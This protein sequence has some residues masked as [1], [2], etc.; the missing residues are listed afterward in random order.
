VDRAIFE[1]KQVKARS[2][3]SLRQIRYVFCSGSSELRMP[4]S[5]VGKPRIIYGL[6]GA[7]VKICAAAPTKSP[8]SHHPLPLL[9]AKTDEQGIAAAALHKSIIS[10]FHRMCAFVDS[11]MVR[12]CGV[13]GHQIAPGCTSCTIF[14]FYR[15]MSFLSNKTIKQI[16]NNRSAWTL[17]QLPIYPSL[18]DVLMKSEDSDAAASAVCSMLNSMNEAQLSSML[19]FGHHTRPLSFSATDCSSISNFLQS[20]GLDSI[21]LRPNIKRSSGDILHRVLHSF[22]SSGCPDWRSAH[23]AATHLPVFNVSATGSP[24]ALFRSLPLELKSVESTEGGDT[25]E[26]SCESSVNQS[27]RKFPPSSSVM[28]KWLRQISVYQ[29]SHA[30]TSHRALLVIVNRSTRRIGAYEVSPRNILYFDSYCLKLLAQRPALAL[31]LDAIR[32]YCN[33]STPG[34]VRSSKVCEIFSEQK[35][36]A[37]SAMSAHAMMLQRDIND[38]FSAASAFIVS[39]RTSGIVPESFAS[40][41]NPKL[42]DLEVKVPDFGRAFI[43]WRTLA[44]LFDKLQRVDNRV[45]MEQSYTKAVDLL[46][47]TAHA[48]HEAASV[49]FQKGDHA[50]VSRSMKCIKSLA[51]FLRNSAGSNFEST[52][53]PQSILAHRINE[54]IALTHTDFACLPYET[55]R[56]K[57]T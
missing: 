39:V 33:I 36:K 24:D 20:F 31:Y 10:E 46:M 16:V 23:A 52:A 43:N 56:H 34:S 8:S 49:C 1:E 15:Q 55:D 37:R 51:G 18:Q 41:P 4:F 2:F 40:T 26:P 21:S 22:C 6:G 53:I 45:H 29:R 47:D 54:L 48:C 9:L 35:L 19:V 57:H 38:H 3:S 30:P 7:I 27:P 50:G 25:G 13:C 5:V 12:F 28:W 32:P 42:A 11:E 44:Q 14:S 17:Q